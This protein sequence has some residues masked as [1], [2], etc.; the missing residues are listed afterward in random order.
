MEADPERLGMMIFGDGTFLDELERFLPPFAGAEA[1]LRGLRSFCAE[2]KPINYLMKVDWRGE[3]I[4]AVSIYCRF[5]DN[6]SA[7]ALADA[8]ADA[9]PLSWHGP[10]LQ[11]IARA[12]G[13]SWPHGIG[14]RITSQGLLHSAVYNRVSM[15]SLEFRSRALLDL[16]LV[17]GF[18]STLEREIT[19]DMTL[20]Y[21][22]GPVG[23]VGVDAGNDGHAAAVKLDAE[24]VPV[25]W[26]IR[27]LSG[28]GASLRR[29]RELEEVALSLAVRN[30]GYLGLK[31]ADT[32]LENWKLY[33]PLQP[34][35]RRSALMPHLDVNKWNTGH[36]DSYQSKF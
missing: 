19:R 32:G 12:L 25:S 18:P 33:L 30:A 17:C 35:L 36:V 16:L 27:F 1:W 14:F 28:R 22:P 6:L 8:L 11:E 31:Y 9:A 2:A 26:A 3:V 23:V 5:V 24:A 10:P 15:P 20:I 13:T 4:L 21:K 34:R 29:M 7:L